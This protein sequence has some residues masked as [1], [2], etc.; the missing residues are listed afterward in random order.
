MR[1]A[2]Q[3]IYKFY[4]QAKYLDIGSENEKCSVFL[5]R[6]GKDEQLNINPQEIS[7]IKWMT[8]ADIDGWVSSEFEFFTPWFLLE[9]R[10]LGGEYRDRVS[11]F[12]KSSNI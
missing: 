6:I 3:Y 9:W 7:D 5:A 4:Y 12:L 8:L 11:D 1:A 10:A 2:L